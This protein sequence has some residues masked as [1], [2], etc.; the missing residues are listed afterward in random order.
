MLREAVLL[1]VLLL[2][3][4]YCKPT[5]WNAP[6]YQRLSISQGD[7]VME[8]RI[9]DID[10][11]PKSDKIYYWM[12]YGQVYYTQGGFDG[13][14]LNDNYKVFNRSG[15][16]ITQG[17][18]EQGLQ[19]GLWTKWVDG[20]KEYEIVYEDGTPSG[21]YYQYEEGELVLHGKYQ[22]GLRNGSFNVLNQDTSYVVKYRKGVVVNKDETT[23]KDEI[24]LDN[25]SI[26]ANGLFKRMRSKHKGGNEE[27]N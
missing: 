19:T 5:V 12:K 18:F 17:R 26:K 13:K 11:K 22:D 21:K 4:S 8:F 20:L 1:C 3:L 24:T 10:I 16:L 15:Q 7:S 14:L 23:L 6:K 2:G 27:E 9:V 25:D